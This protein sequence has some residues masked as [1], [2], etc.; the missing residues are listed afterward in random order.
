MALALADSIGAVGW[1]VNNL[2]RYA[3]HGLTGTAAASPHG[4]VSHEGL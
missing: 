3:L 2:A 4:T 1:D